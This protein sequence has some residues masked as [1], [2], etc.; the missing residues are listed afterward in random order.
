MQLRSAI[1]IKNYFPWL[2]FDD[3]ALKK[4]LLIAF[5]EIEN[6]LPLLRFFWIVKLLATQSVAVRT[7]RTVVRR[8]KTNK[9]DQKRCFIFYAHAGSFFCALPM[10]FTTLL[11]FL[12]EHRPWEKLLH[13]KPTPKPKSKKKGFS[14]I[15]L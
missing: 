1:F 5:V 8:M 13:V 2:F 10:L 6:C 15:L 3:C 11:K 7:V 14:L 4:Y 12:A 9:S